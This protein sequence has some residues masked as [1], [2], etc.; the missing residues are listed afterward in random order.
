MESV[1][2][3]LGGLL[4][5]LSLSMAQMMISPDG[6]DDVSLSLSTAQMMIFLDGSDDDL[7]RRLR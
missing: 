7:S 5:C 4:A 1:G 2:V 3:L 6:S